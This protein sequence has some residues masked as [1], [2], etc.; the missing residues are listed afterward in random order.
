MI[1]D[2]FFFVL[3]VVLCVLEAR[4]GR[5]HKLA[6]IHFVMTIDSRT[7]DLMETREPPEVRTTITPITAGNSS[8]LKSGAAVII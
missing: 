7:Q 3:L 6:F 4:I 1:L 5:T 2:S 8:G